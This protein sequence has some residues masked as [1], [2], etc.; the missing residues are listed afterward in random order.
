MRS[1]ASTGPIQTDGTPP[2]GLS[3]LQHQ[4]QPSSNGGTDVLLTLDVPNDPQSGID[5]VRWM[6]IDKSPN[7]GGQIGAGDLPNGR[8]GQYT[9]VLQL[10]GQLGM[11]PG[12]QYMLILI[13]V[14]G[15]GAD[16]PGQAF[17][18]TKH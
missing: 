15:A 18:F 3:I 4:A 11:Q 1:Y 16:G 7:G 9:T 13:S 17:Q 10:G 8:A 14:N 12:G 2:P 5:R 6:L